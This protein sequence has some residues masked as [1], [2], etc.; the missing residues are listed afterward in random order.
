[1]ILTTTNT[2]EGHK[3]HDYL[4]IITGVAV[5]RKQTGMSFSMKK[6]FDALESN[7]ESV[8]EIAFQDLKKNAT[9]LN[10]NAVVGITI[11]VE[12]IATSGI[13][14]VSITGTAVKVA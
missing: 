12:T 9:A 11:D 8:K 5:N 6:Y 3:I 1:M 2:I 10:A 14:M 4:G 7:I 13:L